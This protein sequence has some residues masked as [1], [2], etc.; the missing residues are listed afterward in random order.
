MRIEKLSED[1]ITSETEK[2][3]SLVDFYMCEH[4]VTQA[5][6]ETYCK[7]ETLPSTEHG[8]G[9]S[10]P[11]YYVSWYDARRTVI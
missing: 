1:E 5:E 3:K 4:E 6:Y 10:Y 11:V 9:A 2:Y 8:M 7:Y